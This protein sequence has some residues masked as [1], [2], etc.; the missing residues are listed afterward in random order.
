M[1][2]PPVDR[3]GDIPEAKLPPHKRLCL[4]TPTSIYEVGESSTA[5]PRPT[6]GHRV[7]Y[8]FIGTLDA[9]ARR[10]RAETIGYGIRDTWVNPR[11]VIEE[12]A[13][14]TLEGVNTRGYRTY[15]WMQDHCINAQESQ[16]AAL[17][18]QVSSQHGHLAMALGEI[19]ALQAREQARTDAPEGTGSSS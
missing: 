7:D 11:E 10:Q 15:T 3:R 19:R 6:G 12:I 2:I 16:I 1:F 9:E 17:T 14:V 8:G 13:P 4:T 5:V 18:A